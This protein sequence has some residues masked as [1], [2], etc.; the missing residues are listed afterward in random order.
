ME[1]VYTYNN[2]IILDESVL[3]QDSL[4]DKAPAVP[5]PP[6]DAPRYG[7]RLTVECSESK[8]HQSGRAAA[9]MQT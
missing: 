8:T 7:D 5:D 4:E 2:S 3:Y 6:D 9:Q 1:F